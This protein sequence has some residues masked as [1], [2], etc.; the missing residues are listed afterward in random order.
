MAEEEP[1]TYRGNCHCAAF[2]FEA[3]LPEIKKL[4]GCNCSY[5][6]KDAFLYARLKGQEDLVFEKGKLEDLVSYQFGPKGIDHMFCGKCGTTIVVKGHARSFQHG[7][8]PNL[9]DMELDHFDGASFGS[10]YE[11]PEFEGP[12]PEGEGEG[13]KFYTGS[14]HCGAVRVGI[15]TFPLDKTYNKFMTECNCSFDNRAGCAWIYPSAKRVSIQGE[16]N[17]TVY[18]FNLG[19]WGKAFCKTCGIYLYGKY[20]SP[21]EAAIAN[22]SEEGKK[23]VLGGAHLR[24]LNIRILNGVDLKELKLSHSDGYTNIPPGYT[25]P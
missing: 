2:V 15:N 23:W 22:L 5:C 21:P 18:R 3:K 11:I 16:E 13:I 19:V 24:P 4:Q 1:K 10:K 25:E 17:V 14:C 9:W 12:K 20:H 7:Q 8:L 6:H